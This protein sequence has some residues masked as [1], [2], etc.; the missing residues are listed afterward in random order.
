MISSRPTI[1]RG[2]TLIELLVVIAIIAV[3]VAL[4][5]PAVQQAR[6]AARRSSCKN[7]LKQLGL[8]MHNYHDLYT[9]LPPAACYPGDTSLILKTWSA[10]ARL[11]PLLDQANLQNLIDW[12]LTYEAQPAVTQTRVPTLL[13]PSDV[14]DRA[15]P[16]GSLTHYPLNYGVNHGTWFVYRR[17]TS[18]GGNGAFTPNTSIRMR[19]FTDGTSNTLAMMEVKGWNPYFRN[20]KTPDVAGEMPPVDESLI[21]GLGSG[22]DF[23]TNSGHTEWVDGHVH[24]TG[25]TTTFT[26]NTFV[27][28]THSDG[29]TYDAD[30]TSCRESGAGCDDAFFTYAAV[31]SRSY[32]TG[33]VNVLVADGSVHSLSENIDLGVYRNLGQRNDGNV[34]REW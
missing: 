16:D 20:S 6:E 23:K 4:L 12:S 11:L 7:N 32:H 26:P 27:P 3:L 24:Q 8:A 13:C 22:G 21:S 30:F 14:N 10:Q 15:R 25:V 2:F 18:N 34:L 5:L 29:V 28:H 17:G 1:R 33:I 31:T 19:D 9:G